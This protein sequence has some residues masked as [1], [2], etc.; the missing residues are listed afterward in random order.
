MDPTTLLATWLLRAMTLIVPV[1]TTAA[2]ALPY[3]ERIDHDG[4]TTT[5]Q[6]RLETADERLT[7]Y[8]VIGM[9][10]AAVVVEDAGGSYDVAAQALGAFIHES[11]L[12]PDVYYGPCAKMKGRCPGGAVCIAQIEMASWER[13]REGWSRIDIAA[14]PE[15]CIREA[16]RRLRGSVGKGAREQRAAGVSQPRWLLSA[17]A[18]GNC[19][20]GHQASAEILGIAWRVASVPRPPPI[21]QRSLL[22]DVL[23]RFLGL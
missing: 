7:R 8:R 2:T 16:V 6:S 12:D 3:L 4:A 15:K 23:I 9:L 19:D 11:R 20:D 13:T 1:D 5:Y 17:Y 14:D 22:A 18:S 10:T 21:P